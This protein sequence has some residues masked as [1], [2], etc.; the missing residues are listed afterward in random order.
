MISEMGKLKQFVTSL[1]QETHRD[2]LS[3]MI[4]DKVSCMKVAQNYDFDYWDG[5]RRN[6]YGGYRYIPGRWR[7]VA[8]QLISTYQLTAGSKLL[9]VGCGKGYLLHE[10]LMIE[11]GLLVTG[12][13]VSSYAIAD[14]TDLVKPFLQLRKAQSIYPFQNKEFDLV[15]SLGT[16]HNL[17]IFD[18]YIA[19]SEIERVGKQGYVMLESYRNQQELFNLQCWALT[20]QSFFSQE[21][22]VWL[23]N[24][25][26]YHGDYEFIYFE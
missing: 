15:I 13:D 20:C 16:L 11:P 23:Y 2:Y 1:H 7:L 4:D 19:L 26:G 6:G 8:E 12:I 21:E 9:D 25:F 3:R 17:E 5:Q 14:S 10:M 18:L 22:W 24:H